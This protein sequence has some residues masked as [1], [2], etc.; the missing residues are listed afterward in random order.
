MNLTGI[1]EEFQFQKLEQELQSLNPE[2]NFSL[3]DLLADIFRGQGVTAVKE[4]FEGQKQILIAELS[5]LKT[6]VITIVIVVLLSAVFSSVKEAFHNQQIADVS[7]YINYLILIILCIGVFQQMLEIGEAALDGIEKFMRIFFPTYCMVMGASAGSVTALGYYQL[8]CLLIYGI[9]LLLKKIMLPLISGYMLF[10]V[11][12]GIWEEERLELLL[13]VWKKGMQACLKIVLGLLTG[14]SLIQSLITPVIERIKDETMY[15]AIESIP[16]IGS[17]AEGAA[18][19]WFGSAVL[20]KNSVGVLSCVLLLLLCL[21]PLFKLA[22]TGCLLKGLAAIL[23]MVGDKRMIHCTAHVGDGIFLL[24]QTVF[25]AIVF[26][27]VLIAVTAYATN[28]GF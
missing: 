22:V 18:K 24:L 28:G 21:A 9:E 17:L 4:L 2:W 27:L 14:A 16:G 3:L 23:G 15:K 5:G 11:M 12:N 7:F 1:Y 13:E 19:I 26:F 10:V 20:I 25:Y 8:A 6:I